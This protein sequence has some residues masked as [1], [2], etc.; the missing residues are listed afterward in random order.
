M[1][2]VAGLTEEAEHVSSEP[3]VSRNRMIT[4]FVCIRVDDHVRQSEAR[5][6][7]HNIPS[8]HPI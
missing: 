7:E 2:W 8:Q 1:I 5:R 3:H 4:N 6:G